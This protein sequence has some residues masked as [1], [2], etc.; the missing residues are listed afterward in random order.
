MFFSLRR[1]LT[2][3]HLEPLTF[4]LIMASSLWHVITQSV[5]YEFL[6]IIPLIVMCVCDV[7]LY[8]LYENLQYHLNDFVTQIWLEAET[9]ILSFVFFYRGPLRASNLLE[10]I[11]LPWLFSELHFGLWHLIIP[12]YC[13]NTVNALW[14]GL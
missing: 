2:H 9:L 8:T 11:Q 7:E 3:T 14:A 13:L 4:F 12:F 1:I 5:C 10:R 6:M